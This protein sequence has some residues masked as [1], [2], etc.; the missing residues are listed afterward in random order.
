MKLLT[1]LKWELLKKWAMWWIIY[2]T[3]IYITL[4]TSM[5][6]LSL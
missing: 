3:T 6:M 4:L 1:K 5:L 2:L